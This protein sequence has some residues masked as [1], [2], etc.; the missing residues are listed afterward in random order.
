[1]KKNY[2][3]IF[4]FILSLQTTTNT[5][6][7]EKKPS[8][9]SFFFSET[10]IR[11]SIIGCLALGLYCAS[12]SNTTQFLGSTVG[13]C[14]TGISIGL[15]WNAIKR[16]YYG[17][18]EESRIEDIGKTL[19]WETGVKVTH[20]AVLLAQQKSAEKLQSAGWNKTAFFIK[21]GESTTLPSWK[22][23]AGIAATQAVHWHYDPIGKAQATEDYIRNALNDLQLKQFLHTLSQTDKKSLLV[24]FPEQN[25]AILYFKKE[26][27]QTGNKKTAKLIKHLETN[28]IQVNQ[29]PLELDVQA[30][31]RS[32]FF[33][34]WIEKMDESLETE[35][36]K[37]KKIGF[38]SNGICTTLLKRSTQLASTRHLS[39]HAA[40]FAITDLLTILRETTRTFIYGKIKI[41]PSGYQP[42]L[43]ENKNFDHL[44]HKGS[45]QF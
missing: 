42:L 30:A 10:M 6:E 41:P 2:S 28:T 29:S 8:K 22:I 17:N 12:N 20:A 9:C 13:D 32:G 26:F 19:L 24:E 36:N 27:E 3:L 40:A 16:F 43:K 31:L 11:S 21:P 33:N 7:P 34:W 4:L 38:S 25:F 45:F 1:M 14:A 23:I 5:A 39:Q 44:F 37:I 35:T 18:P 15:G